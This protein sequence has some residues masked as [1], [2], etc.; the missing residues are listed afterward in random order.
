MYV[1]IYDK[2]IRMHK[3]NGKS[4]TV[5]FSTVSFP[6]VHVFAGTTCVYVYTVYVTS[7]MDLLGETDSPRQNGF[8]VR[9][10]RFAWIEQANWI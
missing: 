8:A 3:C 9:K 2:S 4:D 6:S 10:I 1:C 7:E 5:I